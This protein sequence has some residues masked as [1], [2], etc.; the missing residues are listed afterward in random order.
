MICQTS[1]AIFSVILLVGGVTINR[2]RAFALA[3]AVTICMAVLAVS[4]HLWVLNWEL[5][6]VPTWNLTI[7]PVLASIEMAVLRNEG[8]VS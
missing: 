4:G 2:R 8:I 5:I 1:V 7:L 6:G 3:L